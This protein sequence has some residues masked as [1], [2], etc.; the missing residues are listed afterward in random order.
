[1]C[2]ISVAETCNLSSVLKRLLAANT[3]T[4]FPELQRSRIQANGNKG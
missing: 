1:M 4:C 2:F 3:I